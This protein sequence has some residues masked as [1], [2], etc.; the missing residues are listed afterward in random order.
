MNRWHE[1]GRHPGS[2]Q[3]RVEQNV[4]GA[5]LFVLRDTGTGKITTM[6]AR[7]LMERYERVDQP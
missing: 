1:H 3:L 7:T 4:R 2:R 6:R 5:A